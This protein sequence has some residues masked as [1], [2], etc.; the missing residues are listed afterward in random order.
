MRC[1][2]CDREVHKYGAV[3]GKAFCPDCREA[4]DAAL[5]DVVAE[6]GE[7][8]ALTDTHPNYFETGPPPPGEGLCS[9][10][11]CPCPNT[12]IPHGQ[13][14][15]YISEDL[16]RF[17]RDARTLAE[18]IRKVT[19]EEETG[20]DILRE[21]VTPTLMCEQ[22]ARLRGLDLEVAAADARRWWDTAEAPLRPTPL[23]DG[24]RGSSATHFEQGREAEPYYPQGTAGR[25][26]T[27][28][29]LSLARFAGAEATKS[30]LASHIESG[31][32]C[33]RPP[34]WQLSRRARYDAIQKRLHVALAAG[35]SRLVDIV[36][37]GN[38]EKEELCSLYDAWIPAMCELALKHLPEAD[39]SGEFTRKQR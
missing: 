17:R 18:A 12:V 36:T 38:H 26:Q 11:S 32:L 9:D 35:L 24:T 13:G 15:L 3:A 1:S 2:A 23:A 33:P 25:E 30:L 4:A 7:Q 5:A 10:D 31:L 27:V 22:G 20:I 39:P 29:A 6:C 37:A 14:Y 19:Q 34:W 16:V 21:T 8:P 28:L